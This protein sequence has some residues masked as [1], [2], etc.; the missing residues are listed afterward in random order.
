MAADQLVVCSA[1]AGLANHL[2]FKN[3]EPSTA[4]Y[5]LL[6]LLV[7]PIGLV[8]LCSTIT[9][10]NWLLSTAIF[11][12]VLSSSI[13][14]YRLSPWHPLAS[15]PG[16]T[17][18]KASKLWSVYIQLSGR[19]HRILK[20]LHDQYGDFVRIGPNDVSCCNADAI[21]TVYGSGGFNKGHYYE[22]YTDPALNER[23]LFNMRD[24]AHAN[25]R[26]LW[27]RGLSTDSLKGF[28]EVMSHRVQ[29]ML[30]QID[31]IVKSKEPV[32][33]AAWFGFYAFDFMGDM[34]FGG[35]FDMLKE[36]SDKDGVF[37]MLQTAVKLTS[38]FTQIPWFTPTFNRLP[39]VQAIVQKAF[40]FAMVSGQ[41][42]IAAGPKELKDLWYHLM[43]EDDLEKVK[44]TVNEVL[45]DGIMAVIA[46]S[47]TVAVALTTFMWCMIMH[48]DIHA[49]VR[50]E[51]DAV[52]PDGTS[53]YD[54]DKYDELKLLNACLQES[55]RLFPPVP[56][57]GARKIP[58]GEPRLVAGRLLPEQTQIYMPPYVMHRNPKNF[59]PAPDSFDP[60]R[61]LRP[62][63]GSE[64]L[65]RTAYLAWSYGA[66]NCAAKNLANQEML[67]A[68]AAVLKRYDLSFANAEGRQW[69]EKS[70]GEYHITRVGKL[71]L[72]AE[73]R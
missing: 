27:N 67:M 48:P 19:K 56:T 46:G 14:A 50:A 32:N 5:P 54:C 61:W 52:F 66:A 24:G 44:P 38:V 39:G 17:L 57:N 63:S 36:G 37:P 62:E 41:K 13:V 4:H 25:R 10:S 18:A 47:D 16:P 15:I 9:L 22:P 53:V 21:K 64:I 49:R 20:E 34:A 1:I 11:F 58:L 12:G 72:N 6:A 59:F 65:N 45:A 26:K 31:R 7:Q 71:E 43:D 42:R 33:I 8:A 35:G 51:L 55:L 73:L 29:T 60:D 30:D 2:Y 23:N 28:E 3:N 40:H 69:A 68:L 70:I